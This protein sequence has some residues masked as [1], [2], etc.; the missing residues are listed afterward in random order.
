M[1]FPKSVQGWFGERERENSTATAR[2][3]STNMPEGQAA[4]PRKTQLG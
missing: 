2:E 3:K 1:D 4:P